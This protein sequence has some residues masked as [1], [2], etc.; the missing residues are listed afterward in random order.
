MLLMTLA[1]TGTPHTE[2]VVLVLFCVLFYSYKVFRASSRE[3]EVQRDSFKALQP[4]C[5]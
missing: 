1:R 2:P 3:E 5:D 4:L